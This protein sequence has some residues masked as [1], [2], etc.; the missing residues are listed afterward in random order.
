[1]LPARTTAF[2]T[3]RLRALVRKLEREAPGPILACYEAGPCGYAPQRQISRPRLT[4][5]VI[6]PA[7]IPRKPGERK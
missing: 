6:A 4:C 7:L 2:P 5:Q 1:M 3:G